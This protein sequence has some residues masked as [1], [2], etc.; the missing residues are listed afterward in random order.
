MQEHRHRH[1]RDGADI[2]RENSLKAIRNKKKYT[3]WLY[4][5]MM[6]LSAIM[7]ALVFFAYYIDK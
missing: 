4:W 5:L 6:A 3:K 2:F 7:L 1:R